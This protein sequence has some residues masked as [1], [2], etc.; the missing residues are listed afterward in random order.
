[1]IWSRKFKLTTM[2]MIS[3]IV[4]VGCGAQGKSSNSNN[5]KSTNTAATNSSQSSK[6]SSSSTSSSDKKASTPWDSNKDQQLSDFINQW[7]P[8]MGQTYSK[9]DGTNSIKTEVG[10]TYPDSLAKENINGSAGSIGW[11]PDGSNKYDYNVVAIYNYDATQGPNGRI[12]YLFAFH[13]GQPIALVDQSNNGEPTATETKNSE[14]K[15][16]FEKIA[17][18]KATSSTAKISV[19]DPRIVGIILHQTV[20]PDDDLSREPNFG[21]YVVDGYYVMNN[22]IN[23]ATIFFKINGNSVD[24]WTRAPDSDLSE[25]DTVPNHGMIKKTI[26]CTRPCQV[27]S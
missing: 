17:N 18:T 6:S 11:S 8:T 21:V 12:T 2:L 22:G 3:L 27:D 14:V 15:T 16:N 4:L 7:A 20:Q 1:M 24:Y 13:N 5:Q 25:A 19:S 9:Y 23:V 26:S 10:L